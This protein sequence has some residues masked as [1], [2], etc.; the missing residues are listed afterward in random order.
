VHKLLSMEHG[1]AVQ[2]HNHM[3]ALRCWFEA[4]RGSAVLICGFTLLCGA[5]SCA[6]QIMF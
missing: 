1:R 2:K 4:A 3:K 5:G 6:Q